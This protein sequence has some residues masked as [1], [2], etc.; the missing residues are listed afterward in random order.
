MIKF[1]HPCSPLL[2]ELSYTLTL[3]ADLQ[4]SR[5]TSRGLFTK[6]NER[7]LTDEMKISSTELCL[8]F[9]VY[10]QVRHIY[11]FLKIISLSSFVPI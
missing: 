4:A 3:D 10:V 8:P 6:N 2:T 9:E 1:P 11:V 7:F 5:V